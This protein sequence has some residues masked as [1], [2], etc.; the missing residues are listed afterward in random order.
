MADIL[1]GQS[2]AAQAAGFDA[3]Q[4]DDSARVR[5][6][7][8]NTV[9]PEAEFGQSLT[10]TARNLDC[11]VEGPPVKCKLSLATYAGITGHAHIVSGR[12]ASD[13]RDG[14]DWE[15]TASA[16]ATDITGI[17][18][19][20]RVGSEYCF[21]YFGSNFQ[22]VPPT[23]SAPEIWCGRLVG[24]W[25]P[26][27]VTDPYWA[28]N[29]PVSDVVV[30][31]AAYFQSLAQIPD[32]VGTIDQ[33]Y[34][35]DTASIRGSDADRIVAGVNRLRGY[36]SV[37]TNSV[38]VSGLDS[39]VSGFVARQD[40]ASGPILVTTLGLLVIAVAAMG[41]AAVQLMQ[42]HVA[43]VG[44]LAG[45]GLVACPRLGSVQHGVCAAGGDRDAGRSGCVDAHHLRGR[46]RFGDTGNRPL[47]TAVRRRGP[48]GRRRDSVP[49]HPCRRGRRDERP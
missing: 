23:R 38:F 18:L 35:P 9:T 36:F 21:Q 49:C 32:A 14:S 29:I 28:G 10:L 22:F 41:F 43:Q 24:M 13:A 17:S 12:W 48:H 2:G 44:T 47:A 30:T 46:R 34:A 3:I 40:S 5:A 39:T 15:F 16:H 19:N 20:L 31:H 1:I 33:Q 7:L 6:Q 42:T 26:N 25:L 11:T 8:G 4:R 37:S 27:S 45:P